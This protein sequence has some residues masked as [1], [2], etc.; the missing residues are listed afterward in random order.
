M[1]NPDLHDIYKKYKTLKKAGYRTPLGDLEDAVP[2]VELQLL[3]YTEGNIT[4]SQFIKNAAYKAKKL[5]QAQLLTAATMAN[6]LQGTT[7]QLRSL[8][9]NKLRLRARP[10]GNNKKLCGGTRSRLRHQPNSKK[11][12]S[13]RLQER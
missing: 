11:K 4:L 1:Y 5:Q 7:Q 9:S 12:M 13:K 3:E 8:A 10:M 2:K 6:W